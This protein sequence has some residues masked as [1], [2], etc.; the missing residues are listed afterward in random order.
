MDSLKITEVTPNLNVMDN[1]DLG[2]I[3]ISGLESS[4]PSMKSVNFGPG[5]DLLMNPN[6]QKKGNVSN[7][8]KLDEISDVVGLDLNK[9]HKQE[10]RDAKKN[11]MFSGMKSSLDSN[12]GIKL[13]VEEASMPT[14][15]IPSILKNASGIKDKSKSDD[16]FKKF[17]E[18]PVAPS[19]P[20][21]ARRK[22]PEE[23]LKEKFYYLRRL[24]AMEKQGI[25][26]SKK[27]SMESPLSEMKGEYELIKSEKEKKSSTAFQGK[28]MMAL[29]SGVEFLNN[30]FDPFDLKLDGWA[31]QVNENINEYDELFGELH[32]KYAG[33]ASIAPEIKLLFML[34]GS[35]AM[36]HM[37]NTM[38]KSAM[39]GMDDILKQNPELMQ[40][41]TQAA[42]NTM[43][44][45]NPGFGN[46]MNMAM[47][48]QDPPR[49]APPGPPEEYRRNPPMMSGGYNTGRPDIGMSRGQPDF[50][51]ATNM[52]DTFSSVGNR[53]KRP[54]MKGPKDLKD[55][56]SGL[57][58][59][60][61]QVNGDKPGSV[62]SVSDLKD[63][64]KIDLGRPKKS[65]RKNKSRNEVTLDLGL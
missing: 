26:L 61:I 43:G 6:K 9:Q 47:P 39:P 51:D 23:T 44:E 10:S 2:T 42:V 5:A 49:G 24:E 25:T 12:N 17:N 56:L 11:F 20:I 54:E 32:E 15:S 18:I 29:V 16:G 41:F 40:Q 65:K 27:Y 30:K 21:P 31:E 37:T 58:T 34:G 28:M 63:L 52:E 64:S 53:Q 48:Q 7:E 55:I 8:I 14:P 33:K 50:S 1:N 4:N 36:V 57:K 45:Q 38:F 59:K 60:T 3:K 13:Q 62:A 19:G 22:S 35:A 46:F